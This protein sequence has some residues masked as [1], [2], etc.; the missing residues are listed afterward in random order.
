M[1]TDEWATLHFQRSRS[2]LVSCV[3]GVV[4]TV[5]RIHALYTELLNATFLPHFILLTGLED[6]TSFPPLNTNT[7]LRQLTAESNIITLNSVLV[8]ELFLEESWSTW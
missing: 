2:E 4:T 5:L 8:P 6:H 3:A 1:R 7:W